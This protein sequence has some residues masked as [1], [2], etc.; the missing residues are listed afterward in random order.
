MVIVTLMMVVLMVMMILT[1]TQPDQRA[2]PGV[3]LDHRGRHRL[4]H[5]DADGDNLE[6]YGRGI[7]QTQR[8]RCNYQ[9][10]NIMPIE[11]IWRYTEEVRNITTSSRQ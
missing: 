10:Q 1:T 6:I 2:L 9:R 8:P 7:Q 4:L 11:T 3:P 5:H